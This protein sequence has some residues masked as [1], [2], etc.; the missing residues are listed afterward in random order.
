MPGERPGGRRRRNSTVPRGLGLNQQRCSGTKRRK[1][2]QVKTITRV[3]LIKTHDLGMSGWLSSWPSAFSS[4]HDP[5]V[6]GPSPTSGSL[7]GACFSLRLCLCLSLCLSRKNPQ[8]VKSKKKK[9][10]NWTSLKLN[11][12]VLKSL[13]RTQQ[14]NTGGAGCGAHVTDD[15]HR[16]HTSHTSLTLGHGTKTPAEEEDVNAHLAEEE[17]QA[18]EALLMC[19]WFTGK[20][21]T[22]KGPHWKPPGH[23]SADG[24]TSRRLH[25]AGGPGRCGGRDAG[26]MGTGMTV[27]QF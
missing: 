15:L 21:Q 5:G 8:T 3:T 12:F 1:K 9:S 24:R 14:V 20:R 25:Q 23:C 22:W 11:T 6:P 26:P 27:T 13:L 18:C 10:T 2:K 19:R 16:E 7:Q 17:M 4:G